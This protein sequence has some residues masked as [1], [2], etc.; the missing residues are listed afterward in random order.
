M[1]KVPI[2]LR[3]SLP[4]RILKDAEKEP[5]LLTVRGKPRFVVRSVSV[6]SLKARS[7]RDIAAAEDAEWREFARRHILSAYAD[8]DA[9]YDEL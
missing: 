5:V 4:K 7:D 3:R 1:K 9:I 8:S 6:A 2:D